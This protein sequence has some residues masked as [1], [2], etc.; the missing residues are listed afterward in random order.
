MKKIS[1][2][3][4]E[5]ALDDCTQKKPIPDAIKYLGGLQHVR[6]VL[7]YPEQQD[8][9]LVGPS[10]GWKV[11]AKGNVV[12]VAT[13]RPVMRLDDLLVA[14]RTAKAA[15]QGGIS[16]SIDP[17]PEGIARMRAV[18]R[19]SDRETVVH[20]ME[21][22]MGTQHISVHGVPDSSHFARMLVAADY[23]MKRLSMN[24][25]ASPVCGLN[26]LLA[27]GSPQRRPS[28][29]APLL[30]RAEVRSVVPRC[31][32]AGLGARGAGVKVMTEEDFLAATGDM[33]HSGKASRTAQ[34]WA[35]NMTSKYAELTV[36]DPIYGELQNCMELA[37]VGGLIVKIA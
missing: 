20:E 31:R 30:A 34:T 22:A 19:G 2:R 25:D 15:A 9:V 32:R 1:L 26:E 17:T 11:D 36:A 18:S 14:L 13:G 21:N 4:L 24:L 35:D 23:H 3:R 16:C 7:V 29:H 33:Q 37:I 6:F 27:D 8:I 28:A 10:E 5:A 12:G